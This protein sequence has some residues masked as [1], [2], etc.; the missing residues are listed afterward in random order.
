MTRSISWAVAAA[1]AISGCGDNFESPGPDAL[2]LDPETAALKVGESVTVSATFQK[3]G[4]AV[5]G[6]TVSWSSSDPA[7]RG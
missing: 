3:H 1:I 5:S 4:A 7:T 6:G 2:M